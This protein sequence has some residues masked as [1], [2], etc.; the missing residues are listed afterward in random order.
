MISVQTPCVC[1]EGKPVPTA[2]R[3]D[4]DRHMGR[5]IYRLLSINDAMTAQTRWLARE[6]ADDTYTINV[7]EGIDGLR[8]KLSWIIKE[9]MTFHDA[10]FTSHGNKGVIWFGDEYITAETW[11]SKFYSSGYARL[12]P[13]PNTKLYFAGCRVAGGEPGW[14]FLEAAARTLL[15]V[16][17]GEAIG[18][19]SLGFGSFISGHVRHL[20]G[21]TRQVMLLTGDGGQALRFFENWNRVDDGINRPSE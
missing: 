10:V 18:W 5:K 1:R 19:T 15:T 6:T 14:R 17:G 3:I 16:S 7:D 21:E 13:F 9:G 2:G 20:W 12:F 11:Y 8:S 4:E